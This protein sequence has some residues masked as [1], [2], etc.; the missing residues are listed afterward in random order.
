[1]STQSPALVD[2][3][4]PQNIIVVCRK[5]G[6]STFKRLSKEELNQWLE[7]YSIGDLWRKNIIAGGPVHE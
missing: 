6:T 5:G 3:F 7:E 1:V 2:N 4:E